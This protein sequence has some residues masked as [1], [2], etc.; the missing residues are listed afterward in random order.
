MLPAIPKKNFDYRSKFVP[1]GKLVLQ[2]FTVGQ[3]SILI[4][5]KD[6]ESSSAQLEA[7]NQVI[8]ECIVTKGIDV[9]QLPI[10]VFEEIFLR[11]RQQS[12][13]E[14]IDLAFSCENTI[15]GTVCGNPVKLA[16]DLR[17][18]SI[19][20]YPSHSNKI[21][22]EEPIG[23]QMKYPNVETYGELND[24]ADENELMI[25]CIDLIFD[26]ENVYTREDAS[27]EEFI[28]FWKQL[29]IGQKKKVFETFWLSMPHIHYEKVIKCSK[30]GMDH[31]LE[32]N[33]L[34]EVFH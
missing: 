7:L 13:G 1:K 17:E 26:D 29:T 23:I 33:S 6:E 21:I 10:F 30:C 8:Q 19:K 5:A 34:E 28:N 20:E 25:K 12:A 16:M 4:Q 32:F 22:I 9:S 2:P 3:E 24:T 15:D 31:N 14:I 18:M 11:L 27:E